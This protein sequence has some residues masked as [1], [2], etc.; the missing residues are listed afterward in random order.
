[1]PGNIDAE[2]SKGTNLLIKDGAEIFTE[3]KDLL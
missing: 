2:N 3:T 1:L